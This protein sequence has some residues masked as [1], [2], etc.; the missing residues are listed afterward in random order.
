MAKE[1]ILQDGKIKG[2]VTKHPT[3]APLASTDKVKGV[4][5]IATLYQDN[6]MTI[7]PYGPDR[8][9]LHLS[10]LITSDNK[11]DWKLF[12]E[13]TYYYNRHIQYVRLVLA[14]DKVS[15]NREA[16]EWCVNNLVLLDL[17][18]D[19]GVFYTE[20]NKFY[21]TRERGDGNKPHFYIEVLLLGDISTEVIEWDGIRRY[22]GTKRAQEEPIFDI[23]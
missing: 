3:R 10:T 2:F 7:S 13:S 9:K 1:H 18:K 20:E 6:L 14:N 23:S 21:T 16:Y 5:F 4:W 17:D 15:K 22:A 8:A 19:N 11:E 12:F